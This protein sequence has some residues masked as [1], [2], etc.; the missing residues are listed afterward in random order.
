VQGAPVSGPVD[1]TLYLPA[2][3]P[4]GTPVTSFLAGT[5]NGAVAWFISGGAAHSGLFQAGTAYTANVTLTPAPGYVFGDSVQV[6]YDGA[7]PAFEEGAEGTRSG[8]I[9]FPWTKKPIDNLDLTGYIPAPEEREKPKTEFGSISPDTNYTAGSVSWRPLHGVFQPGVEYTATVTLMAEKGWTFYGQDDR[10]VHAE[11]TVE[12]QSNLGETVTLGITF[13]RLSPAP[14]TGGTWYVAEGGTGD[15]TT[16]EGPLATINE[17]LAKAKTAFESG[18]P[19]WPTGKSA[20][21][22]LLSDITT[23]PGTNPSDN[24]SGDPD[25]NRIGPITGGHPPIILCSD[26]AAPNPRTISMPDA[27]RRVTTNNSSKLSDILLSVEGGGNLTLKNI[28]LESDGKPGWRIS[29]IKVDGTEA[30]LI[31]ES[32]VS[33]L[34]AND[35][36]NE[37]GGVWVSGGGNFTMNKGT[38]SGNSSRG[39][40]VWNQGEFVMNGGIIEGNSAERDD[41]QGMG[42]GVEVHDSGSVFTMNGGTIRDNTANEGGGVYIF[43]YENYGG[44]TFTMNGGTIH[45]NTANKGGGVYVFA[46]GSTGTFTMNG[47][48]IHGNTA[49]KGDGGGVYTE[50]VFTKDGGVIYGSTKANEE[51]E[52]TGLKNTANGNGDAVY[53]GNNP[54]KKR[55]KTAGPEVNLYYPLRGG[56][57]PSDNNW[58]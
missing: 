28:T 42:G 54:V 37:G 56:S 50:G 23:Q 21:I 19:K 15:G 40:G 18:S 27:G 12:V 1:L 47:G 29:L 34:N 2:P 46:Y 43:A 31:F 5:Y 33:I 58:E 17:A 22:V 57:D 20:K 44:G 16:K 45:G 9:S 52:D 38:I 4:D 49:N 24:N 30:E 26:D 55:D 48:T 14:A 10:F 39:G 53:V 35:I 13:Q 8:S 32:G 11:G 41:G 25:Q 51:E 3:V 7:S 36:D 6:I